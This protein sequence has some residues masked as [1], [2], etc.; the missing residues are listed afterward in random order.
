MPGEAPPGAAKDCEY[1][2]P[3]VEQQLERTPSALK[4]LKRVANTD[5]PD[6]IML[7]HALGSDVEDTTC[8]E[9]KENNAEQDTMCCSLVWG[10]LPERHKNRQKEPITKHDVA[11]SGST[12]I[13]A[14]RGSGQYANGPIDMTIDWEP[15]SGES[16]PSQ[17]EYK[18]THTPP[19]PHAGMSEDIPSNQ[20]LKETTAPYSQ[21]DLVLSFTDVPIAHKLFCSVHYAM[22]DGMARGRN[23]KVVMLGYLS[24]NVMTVSP[25][26]SNQTHL[27]AESWDLNKYV[28][29]INNNFTTDKMQ[30]CLCDRGFHDDNM[31]SGDGLGR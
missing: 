6:V 10:W 17:T 1:L 8:Y 26:K 29:V 20:T 19:Q 15:L 16:C 11:C 22:N 25:K 5:V 21:F 28:H 31:T 7:F 9:N 2:L 18:Y 30:D 12:T 27:N 13:T 14:Q 24:N 3:Y 4:F 23:N